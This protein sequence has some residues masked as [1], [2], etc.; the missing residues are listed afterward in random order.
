MSKPRY[1]QCDKE[2]HS[3]NSP[4]KFKQTKADEKLVLSTVN[5][6]DYC[7]TDTNLKLVEQK[8]KNNYANWEFFK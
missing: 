5:R 8:G 2:N 7:N 6:Q 4:K 3:L 1:S